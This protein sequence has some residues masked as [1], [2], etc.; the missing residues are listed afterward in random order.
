MEAENEIL[1]F[2]LYTVFRKIRKES[3]SFDDFY[4]WGDMLLNDFDDVDK[5]PVRII[6]KTYELNQDE[7]GHYVQFFKDIYNYE[8]RDFSRDNWNDASL[9]TFTTKANIINEYNSKY[10]WN[11]PKEKIEEIVDYLLK[12]GKQY[13]KY[14]FEDLREQFLT[15]E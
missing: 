14:Y 11:I 8:G 15:K 7:Q 4:F 5:F 1:I 3:E 2:E 13:E 12:S 6:Y 10:G 9:I